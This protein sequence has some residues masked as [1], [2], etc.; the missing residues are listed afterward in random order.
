MLSNGLLLSD[1]SPYE[2]GLNFYNQNKLNF[3]PCCLFEDR[4]Q[5]Y[6]KTLWNDISD[7]TLACNKCNNFEKNGI[8]SHRKDMNNFLKNINHDEISYLEIDYSNSCNAACGM[9]NAAES[10]TIA[11]IMK[12]ENKENIFIPPKISSSKF[13]S[14]LNQLNLEH[15]IYIKFRSGEPFYNNFHIEVMKKLKN[16]Q[17]I[18]LAYQTNGSFFPKEEW[19]CLAKNFKDIELSFSIDATY[20]KFN[21]IRAGLDFDKVKNN[22]ENIFNFSNLEIK[23]NIVCTIN[24]LNAYYYDEIFNFF[25][26]VKKKFKKVNFSWHYAWG[27]WG[28][29][30]TTP[31]LRNEIEK[32]Y[33]NLSLVK[34]INHFPFNLQRYKIFINSVKEH[35][36]RF[37]LNGEDIFPE[38]YNL[39][40]KNY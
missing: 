12:K 1:K 34:I 6:N 10:S 14:T 40:I 30:N 35:E 36:K 23:T 19:W 15:L 29:E 5:I 28:I 31:E 22:I 17:N 39:A 3:S 13:F 2:I 11:K 33:K 16:T 21:Y 32:K 8:T 27:Q 25:L 7:W 18:T 37:N 26:Y 38:I 9:C 4:T 20:K 24:P